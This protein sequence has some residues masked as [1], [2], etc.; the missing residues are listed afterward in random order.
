MNQ[1]SPSESEVKED[2]DNETTEHAAGHPHVCEKKK[3]KK[4]KKKSGKHSSFRR[5]SEDNADIDDLKR[6]VDKLYGGGY[7][8]PASPIT[9]STCATK[10]LLS[11]QHKNLNPSYEMKRMFGSRVIQ[12]EQ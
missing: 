1:Q 11:V 9:A 10:T 6:E 8:L 2:D 5:S 4:R 12:A 7:D 3:K